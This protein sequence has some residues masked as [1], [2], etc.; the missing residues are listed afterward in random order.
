MIGLGQAARWG[1]A[2]LVGLAVCLMLAG[3][4]AG[5]KPPARSAERLITRFDSSA[6]GF[7]RSVYALNAAAFSEPAALRAAALRHLTDRNRGVHFAAVYALALTADAKSG[8]AELRELLGSRAVEDRLLSAGALASLGDA[9]GLPVLI[10]ALGDRSTFP[11]WDPPRQAFDFARTGLLRYTNE[12]F[13]LKAATTPARV[14]ATRPAWQ[15]WWH[16]AGASVRFDPR[17][18][19]FRG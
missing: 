5:G 13:G 17:T 19:R 8:A 18:A 1:K 2:V 4:A 7:D 16:R 14:A 6:A 12:N 9:R 11:F 15:R 3:S 10:A